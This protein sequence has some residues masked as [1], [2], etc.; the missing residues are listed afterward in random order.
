MS[1]IPPW[2]PKCGT[3][4]E[5]EISDSGFT[6]GCC[7]K[8]GSG[9]YVEYANYIGV[10]E[11]LEKSTAKKVRAKWEDIEEE[12]RRT[13]KGVLQNN[14]KFYTREGLDTTANAFQAALDKLG[15]KN[16]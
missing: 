3:I 5:D 7:K 14:V 6:E 15:I 9:V 8:C 1:R 16:E 13:V 4:S 11:D 10:V 2:C 12:N